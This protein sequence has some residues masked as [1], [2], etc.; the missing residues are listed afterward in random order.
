MIPENI[1]KLANLVQLNLFKNRL[2]GLIPSSLGNLTQLNS[3]NAYSANLEGP[4]PASLG[5]LRKLYVLDLSENYLLNGSIPMEIFL[6]SLSLIL[7]LAYNSL[8]G[9]LPSQ[10]GN[11]VNLNQLILSGNRL[12]SQIPD[13]IGSCVVLERLLLDD[14]MFNGSIP[15]SFKNTKGLQTLN[16]TANKL[17]GGIPDALSSIGALQEMYLAHNSLSGPIPASL[18]KLTSLLAFDA[19]FNDLQGQ[20]PSGGVFGN[21]TAM[22][23]TGNTKLCGGIPQLRLSPCSTHPASDGRKHGSKSLMISLATVGAVLLLVSAT[24]AIWKH[25]GRNSQAPPATIEEQFPRVSYQA[26]ARGTDRFSESNLLGKGRY[27]AV[28]KCTLEGEDAAV[29][30]KV[31]NLEQSGSSKS[32]EAE[33]EALRRIRHRCL[34]RIITCCSSIDARGQ[35]FKA[36]VIDLMP[37]GSLH[38]WLHPKHGSAIP[39]S[40]SL[41]LAQRLDIAV[42]VMDALDYLHNHCQPPIV[43][44]DVKPSNI[45]LAED[46]SARVGD[47]GIAKILPES[48]TEAGQNSNSTM[49]IRGSIGY[50]APEYGQGSPVSTLGD[51]YSL[52]ILLLEMFTGRSPTDDM[53]KESLGLHKF[54]EAALPDR[55]LEIADPT[56][57]VHNDA[58]DNITRSRVHE[59]LASVIKIGTSCSKQQPRERMPIQDA[60]MEMHAIRDANLMLT[61]S[62]AM[63]QP[64]AIKV[65]R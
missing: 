15:Q 38:D 59:C 58:S 21:L 48:A 8:S 52:G 6:P 11:L 63:E 13:T 43:H 9:P 57:W 2:S 4:I 45:L 16:L 3:L 32:F 53:F 17:S 54:S 31:F 34:I 28:Y 64:L 49:G 23:I 24:V 41:S 36:L 27:G 33:C 35:D 12:S 62:L 22:S 26:L 37:N 61:T 56:I 51:V 18:E 5:K 60:A 7:N 20:V 65:T 42:H 39:N 14:N 10:V 50:V 1:G 47:F 55:T 30:V 46:M 19:S 25:K 44:C 29:A 40:T